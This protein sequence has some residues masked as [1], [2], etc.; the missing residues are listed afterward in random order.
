MPWMLSEFGT[1]GYW[2]PDQTRW[3]PDG[4]VLEPTDQEKADHFATRWTRY[5][6]DLAP[7]TVG[8]VAFTW[9][10]RL[11][12]SATWFGLTDEE[13]RRKPAYHALRAAW[14]GE[15]AA[16]FD[17]PSDLAL[18][19]KGRPGVGGKAVMVEASASDWPSGCQTRWRLLSDADFE[20]LDEHRGGCEDARQWRISIPER[21][22]SYRVHLELSKEEDVVTSSTVFEVE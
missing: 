22:G 2:D 17:L 1:D 18:H 14:T 5:V 6:S 12:G 19:I 9:T 7:R 15:P 11:E 20:L 4:I 8:G 21:P 13:R 3:S 10:D 16:A